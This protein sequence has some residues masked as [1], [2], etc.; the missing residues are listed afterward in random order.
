MTWSTLNCKLFHRRGVIKKLSVTT[1][2]VDKDIDEAYFT[3]CCNLA[4][5]R[6]ES[7]FTDFFRP[8]AD[9]QVLYILGKS[10]SSVSDDGWSQ[11]VAINQIT[12]LNFIS[13]Q[14]L[15]RSKPLAMKWVAS[16]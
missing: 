4:T 15:K 14:L 11:N 13:I 5:G 10:I 8:Y 3:W 6:G 16:L 12:N 1:E 7:M 9:V 2:N